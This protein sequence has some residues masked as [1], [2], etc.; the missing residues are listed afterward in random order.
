[1]LPT[2]HRPALQSRV[3]DLP[4]YWQNL[5]EA[6]ADKFCL[7]GRSSHTKQSR[8]KRP[9]FFDVTLSY[10]RFTRTPVSRIQVRINEQLVSGKATRISSLSCMYIICYDAEAQPVGCC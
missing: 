7:G 10:T 8:L 6:S 9:F 2:R 1:M 4:E 5:V 3:A